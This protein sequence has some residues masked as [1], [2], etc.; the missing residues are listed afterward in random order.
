MPCVPDPNST[1]NSPP[2]PG[3][4]HCLPSTLPRMPPSHL[5][6]AFPM[7]PFTLP[8]CTVSAQLIQPPFS[9]ARGS[10]GRPMNIP[11]PANLSSEWCKKCFMA[12]WRHSWA[13][14][15]NLRQLKCQDCTYNFTHI[16]YMD[17]ISWDKEPRQRKILTI[18]SYQW[19]Y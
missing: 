3:N 1:S 15:R 9:R 16:W 19:I 11:A 13:G 6:P 4:A 14:A 18:F 8:Q 10:L 12:L 17:K 2:S 5:F 7:S